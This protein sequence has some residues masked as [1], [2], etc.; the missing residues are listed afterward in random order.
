MTISIDAEN[1]FDEIQHPYM[2]KA[3]K[4]LGIAEMCLNITKDIYDKPIVKFP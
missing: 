4:K 2:T 3:V 1:P